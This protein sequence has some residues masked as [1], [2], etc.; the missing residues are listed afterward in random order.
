MSDLLTM[1]DLRARYG[2]G[3]RPASRT[4]IYNA[5]ASGHLPQAVK[6]GGKMLWRRADVLAKEA[7]LFE[8]AAQ[9]DARS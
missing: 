5:M 6:F 4:F 3:S 1:S 8:R 9:P 2:S 7:A